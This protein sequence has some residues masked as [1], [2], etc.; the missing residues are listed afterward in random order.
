MTSQGNPASQAVDEM[1]MLLCLEKLFAH[2]KANR[3]P[4]ALT[5]SHAPENLAAGDVPVC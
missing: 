2:N 1:A 5:R 3:Q 4:Q